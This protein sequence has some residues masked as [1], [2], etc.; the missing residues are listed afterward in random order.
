MAGGT[1]GGAKVMQAYFDAGVGTLVLMHI[2]EDALKAVKE[3]GIG[4]VIIAGHMAS[5][6]VGINRLIAALETRG[7]EVIRTGGIVEP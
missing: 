2:P 1:N 4:N 6:S 5:D 3:Q 7:L